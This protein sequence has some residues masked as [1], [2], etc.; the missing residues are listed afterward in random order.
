MARDPLP[1]WGK[2]V[3]EMEFV[4]TPVSQMV[5]PGEGSGPSKCHVPCRQGYFLGPVNQVKFLTG[6]VITQRERSRESPQKILYGEK[7]TTGP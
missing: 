6:P 3:R 1:A 7:E 5:M 2:D 4:P